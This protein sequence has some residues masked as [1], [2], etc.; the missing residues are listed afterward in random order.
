MDLFIGSKGE[1]WIQFAGIEYKFRTR[2][3]SALIL[4]SSIFSRQS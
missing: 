4:K 1:T 2:V 3:I